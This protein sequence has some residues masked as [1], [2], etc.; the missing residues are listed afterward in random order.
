MPEVALRRIG[1][2]HLLASAAQ[3]IFFVWYQFR[4]GVLALTLSLHDTLTV[5][6][7]FVT[8]NLLL[9]WVATL[10]HGRRWLYLALVGS[11]T[12]LSVFAAGYHMKTKTTG[13]WSILVDNAAEAFDPTALATGLGY[14]GPVGF[15]AGVLVVGVIVL[16]ERRGQLFSRGRPPSSW[17]RIGT[18]TVA[19][20]AVLAAPAPTNDELT[21]FLRTIYHHYADNAGGVPYEEG[22][23]PLVKPGLELSAAGRA[24]VPAPARRPPLLI[25]TVESFS[26]YFVERNDPEGRPYTPVFNELIGNGLFV[27]HY[28]GNS[29]Q[30]AKGAFAVLFSLVPSIAGK[31]FR[32][33]PGTHFASLPALLRDGGYRT[34]FVQAYA[35]RAF[36]NTFSFLGANGFDALYAGSDFLQPSDGPSVW[37]WGVQDDIFYRRAFDRLDAEH[38]AHP[39]QPLFAMLM[40]IGNHMMFDQVP[41]ELRLRYPEPTTHLERYANSTALADQHLRTLLEELSRREYLRDARVVI[42]ADHA[43]PVGL[44]GLEH[45]GTGYYEEF[46]RVPLLL[47]S[48]GVPESIAPRRLTG[49][50]RS[51]LDVAPTLMHLAG[52]TDV[53]NHFEGF[54]L[55]DPDAPP[56]PVLLVQPYEGRYL[57]VVDLPWKYVKHLRTGEELLFDLTA[58]P[59][60]TTNLAGTAAPE[61]IEPLR[62]GLRAIFRNQMLIARDRVWPH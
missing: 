8:L 13:D 29:I 50:A 48:P 41:P 2:V 35:D 14:I 25:I 43:F 34:V 36:D 51:H 62:E 53:R 57:E 60:E 39:D 22:T 10:A 27:D 1:A 28:Y 12:V 20:G 59:L 49:R 16:G 31:V 7:S 32:N 15:V 54:S 26:Q 6:Y 45:A 55:L 42:T 5:A 18:A 38:A 46:F 21:T 37:G 11:T 44:H 33:Y 47:F 19:Y 3:A 17:W 9:Y 23:W 4:P 24:A 40:T 52:L 58:D 61:V 30:T 56:R